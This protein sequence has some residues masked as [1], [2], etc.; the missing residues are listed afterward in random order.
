[1]QFFKQI[2]PLFLP[3][4]LTACNFQS[5]D[6]DVPEGDSQI[7]IDRS[8]LLSDTEY[9]AS[10]EL[11]GRR[12][13]S[14]GN[15]LA[16]SYIQQRFESLG[17]LSFSGSFRQEFDQSS[18]GDDGAVVAVNLIGYIEGT[19]H[20]DRYIAVTAHYDHLGTVGDNIFNGAD[21]N[22]S[23]TAGMMAAARWF[24]ENPPAN[25]ILFI[26]FD[27]EEQQLAGARHFVGEPVVPLGQIKL[28]VNLDMIATNFEDELY[29]VGTY[30]Y[31]WLL[32]MVETSVKDS[33]LSILFGHDDP[34]SSAQDWTYLSDHG[35]FHENGI[36]FI[37]FGVEDHP[38]YHQPTDTFDT[39]NQEFF[40]QSVLA[41]TGFI[42]DMDE[43]MDE[44]VASSGR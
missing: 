35:P 25:S 14:E 19:D 10:D 41:I 27:A 6:T 13:G 40:Y 44:I 43:R 2:L 30:H 9:L 36:P 22:A 42:E 31:P 32:P 23:G 24:A 16:Q 17:L 39:I 34:D 26:A 20:P 7:N 8:Q 18:G 21:D 37:Y 38:Y 28:N 29:A 4:L 33:P 1:M 11:G 12:T 15:I 5:L 3:L